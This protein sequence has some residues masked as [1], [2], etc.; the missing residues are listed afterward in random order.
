M[1]LYV[2]VVPLAHRQSNSCTTAYVS[3]MG[4]LHALAI[5]VGPR[6]LLI[7]GIHIILMT[8]GHHSHALLSYLLALLS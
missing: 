5:T 2:H 8:M 3:T 7:L 1:Y 6:L 4:V